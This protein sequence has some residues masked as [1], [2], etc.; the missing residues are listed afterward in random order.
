VSTG[1]LEQLRLA[2]SLSPD[3]D[4]RSVLG[5]APLDES[6]ESVADLINADGRLRLERGLGVD[7]ARYMDAVP[8]LT[9]LGGA[10][11]TAI[12]MSLRSL[13]RSGLSPERAREVLV[14]RFPG[15]EREIRTASILGDVL[16]STEGFRRSLAAEG[17][18]LPQE[19]GPALRDGR[20][21]YELR[22]LIGAGAHGAVYL[23]A[24]RQLSDADRPAWVAVK[25]LGA[26][27]SA[28]ETRLA[29]EATKARRVDHPNVVRVLDRGVSEAGEPYLAYEYVKG[30]DLT[31]WAAG[32]PGPIAERQAAS[33][34]AR[35]ARGLQ[36]AHSAGLA[37][38]DLKPANVLITDRGEPKIA[39]FGVAVRLAGADGQSAYQR[40]GS[41]AFVAPEQFRAEPGALSPMADTYA[42]G[43]ILFWLLTRKYPNGDT[44]EAVHSNLAGDRAR[45][46]P[47]DP[48]SVRA[49]DADLGAICRRA[50]HPDPAQRYSAAE[51]LAADLE[52]WLR[53]E[54]L[55]WRRTGAVRRGALL[56]RRQP[57]AVALGSALV[58]AVFLGLG[59]AAYVRQRTV[60]TE[61][62]HRAELAEQN[63][64]AI[65]VRFAQAD[66]LLGSTTRLVKSFSGNGDD[67]MPVMTIIETMAGPAL[68]A[69][70][71]GPELWASRVDVIRSLV[72]AAKAAGRENDL[73]PMLWEP[74]LGYWLVRAGKLDEAQARLE[75][76]RAKWAARTAEGDPW[77]A[78]IDAM[79]ACISAKR[80]VTAGSPDSMRVASGR[81]ESIDPRA[82]SWKQGRLINRL[83]LKT[84]TELYGPYGLNDPEK[85]KEADAQLQQA[86]EGP[87]L[88]ASPGMNPP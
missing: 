76:S 42:A 47:P 64:E 19:F 40:L 73:E 14:G 13:G 55:R 38:C 28:D 77:L 87:P 67:W 39:D 69:E 1:T 50:L 66:V 53:H 25:V 4:L 86:T 43:G 12:E 85:Y 71:I 54:P 10:L 51:A 52:A 7:L 75:S 65:R 32:V 9:N 60:R 72:E 56:V 16:C 18:T 88:T 17:R 26:L 8:R 61:L 84:R 80:A 68:S 81:M 58:V 11:D 2:Y 57:L 37:H 21:R 48:S 59:A 5:A 31:A 35:I 78:G 29:D 27:G 49:I 63:A 20:C 82:A 22:E 24:D 34:V 46:Q 23:A 33:L 30:G 45:Q 79:L 36:A 74:V 62:E 70:G 15:I 6:D 41:L 44:A 83:V 3:V